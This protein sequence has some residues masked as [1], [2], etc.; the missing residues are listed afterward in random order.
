MAVRSK[1]LFGPALVST[2]NIALYTCPP[3]ETALIKSLSLFNQ[4][5]LAAAIVLHINGTGANT[6]V[7]SVSVGAGLSALDVPR[8]LVLHPGD[9]LRGVTS[10]GNFTVAGYGA[11]LEGV[12]D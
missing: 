11:E 5:A 12:A 10:Q 9:V 1:R 8:F 6:I 7:L 4:G 3:G 2:T